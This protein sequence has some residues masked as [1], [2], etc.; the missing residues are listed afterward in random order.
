[1]VPF[2]PHLRCFA[3][4][5]LISFLEPV[6]AEL[7]PVHSISRDD[8]PGPLKGRIQKKKSIVVRPE[9]QSGFRWK[10]FVRSPLLAGPGGPSRVV[11][12]C[13]G[14]PCAVFYCLYRSLAR[15]GS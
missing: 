6:V 14:S 12:S 13:A 15:T 11:S 10:G 1:M 7:R 4:L 5:V 2:H 3:A 9:V 8:G